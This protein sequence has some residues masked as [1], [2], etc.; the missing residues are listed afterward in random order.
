MKAG[1][2]A[3]LLSGL[4]FPGSGQIYL[5]RYGRGLFFMVLVLLGL[6]IV[7]AIA[8]VD[9]MEGMAAGQIEGGAIDMNALANLVAASLAHSGAYVNVILI[10]IACCWIYSVI[11]AYRIGKKSDAQRS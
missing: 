6:I 10:F 2:K 8:A 1:V 11:D 7:A 9:V 4:V 3:A 5:K